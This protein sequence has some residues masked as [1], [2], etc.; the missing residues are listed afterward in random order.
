MKAAPVY[1]HAVVAVLGIGLGV[2]LSRLGFT[3]FGELHEM[4]TFAESRLFLAF[5]AGMLTLAMGFLLL[6][7]VAS[8]RALPHQ[9]I[10][11]GTIPG[12]VLFGLGWA[13]CGACPAIPLV[14][15]GEGKLAALVVIVGL[16]LGVGLCHLI[17]ARYL[18]WEAVSCGE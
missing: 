6:T 16:V 14:Q 9:P 12:A 17:R 5:A 1:R 18:K 7:R 13:L 2:A 15:L 10:H 11:K 8:G 4:F 3:D